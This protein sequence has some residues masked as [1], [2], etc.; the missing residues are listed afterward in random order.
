MRTERK[1]WQKIS[2]LK[3]K[4]F[5]L[6]VP[7]SIA[8]HLGAEKSGF[9][10]KCLHPCICGDLAEEK[11]KRSRSLESEAIKC[12]NNGLV[13]GHDV[14]AELHCTVLARR[15]FVTSIVPRPRRADVHPEP[16]EKQRS[17]E[18]QWAAKPA[19]RG[20]P[21]SAGPPTDELCPSVGFCSMERCQNPQPTPRGEPLHEPRGEGR[22]REG[23]GQSMAGDN[24]E[25]FS[26]TPPARGVPGILPFYKK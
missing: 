8:H 17:W 23:N 14:E 4:G 16:P 20:D 18:T 21:G 9:T 6:C 25:R 2:I 15:C 22:C 12:A 19:P 26:T 1:K 13:R 5:I 11:K 24:R 3:Q 10:D 7:I